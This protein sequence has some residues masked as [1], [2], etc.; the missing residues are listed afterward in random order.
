MVHLYAISDTHLS[1]S[2]DKGMEIYSGWEHYIDKLSDNWRQ[3]VT[4]DDTVVIAGDISWSRDITSGLK[5]FTFLESLPGKKILIKGNHD[6]WWKN[7]SAMHKIFSEIPLKSIEFLR[8]NTIAFLNDYLICGATGVDIQL[9]LQTESVNNR[10]IMRLENSLKEAA[11]SCLKPIV[12]VH[13]PPI[14]KDLRGNIICCTDIMRLFKKYRVSD[15][16]Y[17]HIHGDECQKAFIGEY[18]GVNFHLISADFV[19]FMPIK[20]V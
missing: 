6:Y 7:I 13:F 20:V 12:F 1:L 5:D 4:D 15:C 11:K 16:Y 8:N 3:V 19:Q 14:M 18:E 9:L 17:G 10:N 2:N